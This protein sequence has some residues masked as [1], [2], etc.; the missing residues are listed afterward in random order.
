MIGVKNVMRLKRIQMIIGFA[1]I[2]LL[3]VLTAA[4]GSESDTT[5]TRP[6]LDDAGG[7]TFFGIGKTSRI[8]RGTRND[9]EKILGDAA[10]ERRG[11]VDLTL[12][13]KTFLQTHFP[14]LDHINRQLNSA[15]GLRVKHRVVRLMYR[16]A[17]QKGLPYDLVELLYAEE[18]RQP[19]LIKLHF[20]TDADETL[21]ALEEKYGPPQTL[22]WG[23][24]KTVTRIWA[25]ESDYLFYAIVPKR[26][27]K[28]E[29]RVNIYFTAALEALIQSEK[30][31]RELEASRKT[32]L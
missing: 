5:D 21:K 8:T 24:E 22:E 23:R 11:I 15:I 29:Y 4:C 32:G 30:S 18:T 26:G 12:N 10:V 6:A 28:V 27:N 19:L 2:A 20:K 31:K 9:L 25:Q 1:T 16:Y 13:S 14:E 3:L 7:F 17:R